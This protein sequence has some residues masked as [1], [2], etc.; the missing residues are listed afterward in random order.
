MVTHAV[1]LVGYSLNSL[2]EGCAGYWI[3]QNSW[4]AMWGEKGYF[5]LCIPLKIS[6][7]MPGTCNSQY[8]T[9]LPDLGL[10]PFP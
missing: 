10:I 4:G 8:L 7:S 1:T 6:E 9:M 2:T 3:I 5:K